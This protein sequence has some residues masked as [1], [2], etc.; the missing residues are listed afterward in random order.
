M[1]SDGRLPVAERHNYKH[2]GNAIYRIASE[3]GI[4]VLWSGMLPS[5][6]R[7]MVGT[8]S[9]ISTYSQTKHYLIRKGKHI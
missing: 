1:M 7:A 3:E 6:L 9:Q 5:M 4:Q 8:V 2:V